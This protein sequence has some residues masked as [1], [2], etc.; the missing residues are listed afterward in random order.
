MQKIDLKKELKSLY[1]PSAKEVNAVTVPPMN[2]IMI[3]GSGD[4]NTAASYRDAIAALYALSYT[5][6]FMVKKEQGIDYGVMPLEGLWWAGDLA[7]F[8]QGNDN[9]KWTAMIMQPQYI[10]KDLF[11]T[12]L[13]QVKKKKPSPGL[14]LARFERYDEGQSAKILYIGPYSAEGPTIEKVHQFIESRGGKFDG[15][16]QRHH[17]IYLGDPRKASPDKLKTIIRQPFQ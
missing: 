11:E 9:W 8:T 3:D 2:F 16:T 14:E 6:K 5:L 15:L 7:L 12:A 13:H 4:P 10:T 17:E 1:S